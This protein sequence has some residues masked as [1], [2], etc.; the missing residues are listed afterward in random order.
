MN[1]TELD[2]ADVVRG[3]A[4]A[5]DLLAAVKLALEANDL[6]SPQRIVLMLQW[7]LEEYEPT[8]AAPLSVQLFLSAIKETRM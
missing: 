5:S 1:T 7:I 2:M 4:H 8:G 6:T 3:N